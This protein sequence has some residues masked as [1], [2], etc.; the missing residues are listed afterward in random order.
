V[1]NRH[2]GVYPKDSH[3]LVPGLIADDNNRALA[4]K[5][6]SRGIFVEKATDLSFPTAFTLE[7]WVTA[8]DRRPQPILVKLDSWYLQV[9][10][11]G[12]AGVGVYSGKEETFVFSRSRLPVS[13]EDLPDQGA[14]PL[15][16]AVQPEAPPT[17]NDDGSGSAVVMLLFLL[18]IAVGSWLVL[19]VRR[20]SGATGKQG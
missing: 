6:G 11:E 13:R 1:L 2:P 3:D 17:P 8:G 5:A 20:R 19:R 4:F 12:Q 14:A 16:V 10:P 9:N 15:P 18:S 7:A